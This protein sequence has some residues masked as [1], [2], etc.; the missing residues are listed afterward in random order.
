MEGRAKTN[1]NEASKSL[2]E[3]KAKGEKEKEDW[4]RG[5][6]ELLLFCPVLALYVSLLRITVP[7]LNTFV[8]TSSD[9]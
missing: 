4:G 7:H 9:S 2:K 3:T 1:E 8:R 5:C 6:R